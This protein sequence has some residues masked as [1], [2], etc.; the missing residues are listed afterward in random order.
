M[1]DC[2]IVPGTAV[3]CAICSKEHVVATDDTKNTGFVTFHGNV[4]VGMSGG[5]VG[6]NIDEKTGRVYRVTLVCRTPDCVA[7]ILKHL[8]MGEDHE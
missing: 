1:L 2:L 7:G 8:G 5:V 6:N 3:R 4:C